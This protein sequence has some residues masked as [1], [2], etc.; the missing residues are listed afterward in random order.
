MNLAGKSSGT[1]VRGRIRQT[2]RGRPLLRRQL[3]LLAGRW[4]QSRGLYRDYYLAY[5]ARN[6][7]SKIKGLAAVARKLVPLVLHI[8]QTGE[9]FDAARW[10][11]QR[12]VA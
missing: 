9:P 11:R 4:C 5:V 12:H 2:K 3:F 1:S 8:I 7:G 10:G 6:G